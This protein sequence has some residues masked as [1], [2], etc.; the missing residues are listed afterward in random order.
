[1]H[2]AADNYNWKTLKHWRIAVES[3]NVRTKAI[4][5]NKVPD[6]L[7][8]DALKLLASDCFPVTVICCKGKHG[9]KELLLTSLWKGIFDF[10]EDKRS[11]EIEGETVFFTK[12][13]DDEK[14]SVLSAQVPS[15]WVESD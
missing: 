6:A 8:K 1:M 13:T 11:L 5:T 3:G 2:R 9:E 15:I 14:N 4:E 7:L 12:M 10:L